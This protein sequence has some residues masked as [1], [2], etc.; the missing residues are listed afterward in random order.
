MVVIEHTGSSVISDARH[1]TADVSYRRALQPLTLE[2]G[3]QAPLVRD[4]CIVTSR[5]LARKVSH[6]CMS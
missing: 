1:S 6:V 3:E 5:L 4:N 2:V